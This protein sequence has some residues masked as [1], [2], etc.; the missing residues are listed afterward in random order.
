MSS[1]TK[2]EKYKRVMIYMPEG[3]AHD[4]KVLAAEL[5]VTL[6]ELV[7]RMLETRIREHRELKE[8]D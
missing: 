1:E 2:Q 7:R 4:A 5:G 3:M 6:S 8:A